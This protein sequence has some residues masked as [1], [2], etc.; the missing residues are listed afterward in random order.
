MG[1]RSNNALSL[2]QRPDVDQ[3]R[4]GGDRRIGLE[5]LIARPARIQVR[6]WDVNQE[7]IRRE[8][9][10][11]F[12]CFLSPGEAE[13]SYA[14][15]EHQLRYLPQETGIV[16]HDQNRSSFVAHDVL[17]SLQT[18]ADRSAGPPARLIRWR[19]RAGA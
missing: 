19:R 10:R 1:Y 3:H 11:P 9:T 8:M 4:D 14:C 5:Q 17:L 6:S 7:E 16:G 13:R 12:Q 2:H 18:C 15:S